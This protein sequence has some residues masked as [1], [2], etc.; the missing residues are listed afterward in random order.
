[1]EINDRRKNKVGMKDRRVK[2]K[3]VILNRVGRKGFFEGDG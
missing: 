3:E 1:M 2:G